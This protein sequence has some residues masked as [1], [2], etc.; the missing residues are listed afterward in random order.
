MVTAG[1]MSAPAVTIKSLDHLV[2]TVKSVPKSTEW[3]V[4]NLGMK[5]ESFVSAATPEITRYSLIF[6]GQKINLHELGKVWPYPS[7]SIVLWGN[8]E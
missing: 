5:S 3:Y 4:E 8:I 6:G 1:K 2:L 7:V